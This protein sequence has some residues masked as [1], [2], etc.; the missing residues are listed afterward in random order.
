MTV[1]PRDPGKDRRPVIRHASRA[2][3]D[4]LLAGHRSAPVPRVWRSIVSVAM[5]APFGCGISATPPQLFASSP[6]APGARH[7]L[8]QTATGH[9]ILVNASTEPR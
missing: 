3:A 6:L 5:M 4:R 7:R 9:A 8:I 2:F 1:I